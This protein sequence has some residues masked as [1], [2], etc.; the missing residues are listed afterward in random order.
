MSIFY[1]DFIDAV[2]WYGDMYTAAEHTC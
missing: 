2:V 1:F